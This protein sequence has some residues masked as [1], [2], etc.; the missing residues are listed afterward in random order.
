MN[1]PTRWANRL[2]PDYGTIRSASG[3]VRRY[4]QLPI[5]RKLRYLVA[6]VVVAKNPAWEPVL[7]YDDEK[8][9]QCISY[10]IRKSGG[11]LEKLKVI[12][13]LYL[14]DRLSLTERGKPLNFDEYFS[15]PHGPVTSASLNGINGGLSHP[16][17][18]LLTLRKDGRTLELTG[19]AENDRL[20][21]ADCKILDQVWRD[22]G[23]MRA[24]DIRGWTHENCTEYT[25]VESGRIQISLDE[26]L[27]AVGNPAPTEAAHNI[28]SLQRTI[29]TLKRA[30]AN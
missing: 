2:R 18:K 25:E 23:H 26:L 22:F 10:F 28:R 13:L 20:S 15:M 1:G 14:A 12:K 7:G 21:R 17:W 5:R 4:L 6:M 29:G 24:W 3:I 16:S 19:D 27:K 8:A 30:S 11:R 9:V